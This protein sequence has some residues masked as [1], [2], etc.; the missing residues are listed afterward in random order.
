MI[1]VYWGF[2]IFLTD[3]RKIKTQKRNKILKNTEEIYAYNFS[4]GLEADT[5]SM[6]LDVDDLAGKKQFGYGKIGTTVVSNITV[7]L[8]IKIPDYN[9]NTILWIKKK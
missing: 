2:L 4:E 5:I 6:L 3:K 8:K 9:D 7:T 1:F